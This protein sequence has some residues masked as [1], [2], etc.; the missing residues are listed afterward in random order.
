M[1][2]G[3]EIPCGNS[4][5]MEKKIFEYGSH[6]PMK[7]KKHRFLL[8]ANNFLSRSFSILFL[9][10]S[11]FSMKNIPQFLQKLKQIQFSK[12]WKTWS[13]LKI[14][15]L[16]LGTSYATK[17]CR[18]FWVHVLMF[19][20]KYEEDSPMSSK[21][22][23]ILNLEKW[24]KSWKSEKVIVSNSQYLLTETRYLAKSCIIDI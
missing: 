2:V 10:S 17:L 15:M 6:F 7:A 18:K 22:M 11:F 4:K 20:V 23:A 16:F 14:L 12:N 19:I 13:G 24:P 21:V 5:F 1:K 8:F 3:T 9:V